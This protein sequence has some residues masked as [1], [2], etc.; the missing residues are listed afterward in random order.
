[1]S[2]RGWLR[3]RK[4]RHEATSE[5]ALVFEIRTDEQGVKNMM[6]DP[7]TTVERLFLMMEGLLSEADVRTCG[8]KTSEEAYIVSYDKDNPHEYTLC[9]VKRIQWD[10]ST[11]EVMEI[12]D[13]IRSVI[14]NQ[15][16]QARL[17][18]ERFSVRA[19]VRDLA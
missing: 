4:S 2:L 16:K 9:G 14:N 7:R 8:H 19:E 10:K 5:C 15:G 13:R 11:E 6:L 1:M 18:V 3:R 12:I 17:P